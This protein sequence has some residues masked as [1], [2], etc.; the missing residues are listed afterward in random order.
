MEDIETYRIKGSNDNGRIQ[1]FLEAET[2]LIESIYE[3]VFEWIQTLEVDAFPFKGDSVLLFDSQY[4]E[5]IQF[6]DINYISIPDPELILRSPHYTRLIGVWL[7][8]LFSH[9]LSDIILPHMC[10]INGFED[11]LK[12]TQ[13]TDPIVFREKLKQTIDDIVDMILPDGNIED[14]PIKQT[15]YQLYFYHELFNN[16]LSSSME[17]LFIPFINQNKEHILINISGV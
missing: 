17:T 4:E 14:A 16:D 11:P 5:I 12:L 6:I 7:I 3:N 2:K 8:E 13:I 9:N 15:V 10:K 1:N